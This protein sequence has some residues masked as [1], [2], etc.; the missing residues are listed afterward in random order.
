MEGF[1]NN[2]R[3]IG[4]KDVFRFA[5]NASTTSTSSKKKGWG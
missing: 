4:L 1:L 3:R 5:S 2:P